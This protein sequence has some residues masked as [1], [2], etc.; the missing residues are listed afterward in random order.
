M[1]EGIIYFAS[2]VIGHLSLLNY[3]S[4]GCSSSSAAAL[5]RANDA[6]PQQHAPSPNT[7]SISLPVSA[8]PYKKATI[9][10]NVDKEPPVLDLKVPEPSN[11]VIKVEEDE[12]G[13]ELDT[14]FMQQT[15]V[16]RGGEISTSTRPAEEIVPPYPTNSAAATDSSISPPGLDSAPVVAAAASGTTPSHDN[17][18]EGAIDFTDDYIIIV[19]DINSNMAFDGLMK[20]DWVQ[21]LVRHTLVESSMLKEMFSIFDEDEDQLIDAIQ[22]ND[23]MN[24]IH[25]QYGEQFRE[26][27]PDQSIFQSPASTSVSLNNRSA[28]S[29][30]PNANAAADASSMNLLKQGLE[31]NFKFRSATSS[32]SLASDTSHYSSDLPPHSP[33]R[34]DDRPRSLDADVGMV[35]H[36]AKQNKPR[37]PAPDPKSG[38][39]IKHDSNNSFE[40]EMGSPKNKRFVTVDNGELTYLDSTTRH[41]QVS[42]ENRRVSLKGAKINLIGENQIEICSPRKKNKPG[43]R[44][45]FNFDGAAACGSG[46]SAGEDGD[47]VEKITLLI[48]NGNDKNVWLDAINNHINFQKPERMNP[49]IKASPI[50]EGVN[51]ENQEEDSGD[52][53]DDEGSMLM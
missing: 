43:E 27:F 5:P 47:D 42:F 15:P 52:D 6:P 9:D 49:V 21:S 36:L 17:E 44:G 28:S 16:K 18:I 13:K 29:S 45:M 23:L 46:S 39:L 20:L 26:K 22:F 8:T 41:K 48:P 34:R 2:A 51:E 11:A 4:M 53:H 40:Q 38:F 19:G 24:M 35:S 31:A 50:S 3:T 30:N 12:G 10:S 33:V 32:S 14:I 25:L 37:K 1:V 7:A